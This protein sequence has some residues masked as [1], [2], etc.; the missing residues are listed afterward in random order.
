MALS[1]FHYRRNGSNSLTSDRLTLEAPASTADNAVI[2]IQDG[3]RMIR[4]HK[5]REPLLVSDKYKP[6]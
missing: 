2:D 6:Y 3:N 5:L 1:N 4:I